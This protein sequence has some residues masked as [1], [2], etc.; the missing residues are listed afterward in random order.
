MSDHEE[1]KSEARRALC[2]GDLSVLV[3]SL[4]FPDYKSC[5]ENPMAHGQERILVCAR[6]GQVFTSGSQ[7]LP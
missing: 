4:P 2:T 1:K 3:Q 6:K 7:S 5:S